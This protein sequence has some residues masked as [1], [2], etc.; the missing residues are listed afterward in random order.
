MRTLW[1]NPAHNVMYGVF[2]HTVATYSLSST[3]QPTFITSTAPSTDSVWGFD[4]MPQGPYAYAAIQNGNPRA[5]FQ[6]P[7]IHLLTMSDDGSLSDSRSVV[8]LP[9]AS[10]I[11]GDLKIDP[12]GKFVVVSNGQR[13]EQLSVYAIQSD[14]SLSEVPGTPFSTGAEQL[15]Y[16]AFDS[17]GKSF[18]AV[19]QHAE[20]PQAESVEVFSFDQS[21]GKL[22]PIQTLDQP[23]E[24]NVT[25]L[26]V[27]G[28][29]VYLTNVMEGT[30][31]TITVFNRDANT[32]QLTQATVANVNNALGQ[33]EVLH[34]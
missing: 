30:H 16:M 32:G 15:R 21:T 1:V 22:T 5:G 8:T 9:N 10:G 33:T 13:N 18:Y 12:S 11:A 25:W 29:L 19:N 14:G 23:N 4:F 3:G 28:N 2:Q 26:S 17:T 34:E 27:D 20:E 24:Q 6:T 31:S 7:E